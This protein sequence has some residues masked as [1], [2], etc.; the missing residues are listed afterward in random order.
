MV[1]NL[2]NKL[3]S[4]IHFEVGKGFNSDEFRVLFT[5]TAV[6]REKNNEKTLTK[7]VDEIISEY[8]AFEKKLDNNYFYE[9]QTSYE[10]LQGDNCIFVKSH[11]EKVYSWNGKHVVETGINH[12]VIV[13]ESGKLKI[14][15]VLW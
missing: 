4:L 2:L 14:D 3:Y 7:T 11:Y 9:K 12:I 8:I 15:Y 1:E 6:L 13:N 10:M 5:S